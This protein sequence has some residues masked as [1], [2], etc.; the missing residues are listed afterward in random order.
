M[1]VTQRFEQFLTNLRLTSSQRSDG[2]TKYKGVTQCLNKHYYGSSSET[3]HGKLVGSW[4]KRTEIRPPRDIDA[5][6]VL[7]DSVFTQYSQMPWTTNKQSALLQEVKGVLQD[8]Y[9]T[10][11]MSG[12]GQ[13]VVIP[14]TSYAVE[15]VPAFA[16]GSQFYICN[17]H[18]GGSY[19]TVDP[20]AEV[21]RLNS[22]DTTTSG[23]TRDLIRMMKRWQDYCTVPIKSFLVE[24][25]AISFLDTWEHRGKSK[26]YYDW[27]TRDFLK[28]LIDR[29][30]GYV[31]VPG[32]Y[33]IINIGDQWKSRA[34]TAFNRAQKACQNEG[35]DPDA[36]GEEWQKIFG[37]DIPRS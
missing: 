10:T 24:L 33:E 29:A 4:G 36:A 31:T 8:C 19:K 32:T 25:L 27:M 11:K 34:E 9:S 21:S 18:G 3:Q 5:I 7:P 12:D 6:F 16:I 23:N 2:E 22:S 13:V 37:N 17:T 14:F 28:F 35:G 26:T 1:T 20:D 30:N 15:L